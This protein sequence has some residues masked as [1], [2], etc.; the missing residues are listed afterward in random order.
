MSSVKHLSNQYKQLVI[1]CLI[2]TLNCK[3]SYCMRLVKPLNKQRTPLKQASPV[4]TLM[5]QHLE[6]N[7]RPMYLELKSNLLEKKQ[8]NSGAKH[9]HFNVLNNRPFYKIKRIKP[10]T[11]K[12]L[13]QNYSQPRNNSLGKRI[14]SVSVRHSELHNSQFHKIQRKEPKNVMKIKKIISELRNNSPGKRKTSVPARHSKFYNRELHKIKRKKP[15]NVMK[16]KKINFELR[17]NLPSKR[18]VSVPVRYSK[19]HNRQLHKAKRIVP[20]NTMLLKQKYSQSRRNSLG[21][22]KISVPVR[23][24]K[25]HNRQFHKIKRLES[26]KVRKSKQ[27]ISEHRNKSLAKQK[28]SVF[29]Q[30]RKSMQHRL[31]NKRKRKIH[32]ISSENSWRL[33]N[34]NIVKFNKSLTEPSI[35]SQL[36]DIKYFQI[37]SNNNS[38]REKQEINSNVRQKRMDFH[39]PPIYRNQTVLVTTI[40]LFI[41]IL[42]TLVFSTFVLCKKYEKDEEFKTVPGSGLINCGRMRIVT[43]TISLIFAPMFQCINNRKTTNDVKSMSYLHV[44]KTYSD[45]LQ[46]EHIISDSFSE[47]KMNDKN[48]IFE[49]SAKHNQNKNSDEKFMYNGAVNK[50]K[51][52][53]SD[54]GLKKIIVLKKGSN[55]LLEKAER[56]ISQISKAN[57]V[58]SN[59]SISSHHVLSSKRCTSRQK[60]GDDAH[61]LKSRRNSSSDSDQFFTL[62]SS[63]PTIPSGSDQFLIPSPS[64]LPLSSKSDIN[65][66]LIAQITNCS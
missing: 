55:E 24:S 41:V 8:N 6:K 2:F 21:K 28:I 33:G 57:S 54:D 12:T 63:L 25:F 39:E 5:S 14:I 50:P 52:N 15:K 22:R 66:E 48:T 4:Q 23:N 47:C 49:L 3:K 31:S 45:S 60:S 34:V 1:I 9:P 61:H 26:N 42:V 17:K 43:G 7:G 58:R 51:R 18:K 30:R 29:V 65:S 32:E 40:I 59:D 19:F 20:K 27:N 64:T 46:H 36:N 37:L 11:I 53:N 16:L 13:K 56:F 35:S 38:L 10:K 62:S 44:Q